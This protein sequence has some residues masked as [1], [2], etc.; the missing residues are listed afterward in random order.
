MTRRKT[1]REKQLA[2]C[3]D[4]VEAHEKYARSTTQ[5]E[6]A[7]EELGMRV[8]EFLEWLDRARLLGFDVDRYPR[9]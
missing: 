9:R 5:R 4:V 2:R 6:D 1:P 8:P 7:A 3:L